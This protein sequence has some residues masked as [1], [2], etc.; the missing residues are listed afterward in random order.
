MAGAAV[1]GQAGGDQAGREDR[2]PYASL[3]F[4]GYCAVVM[5]ELRRPITGSELNRVR[6]GY[7]LRLAPSAVAGLLLR[8]TKARGRQGRLGRPANKC[9]VSC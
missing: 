8:G 2:G 5:H 6:N 4:G 9:P 3:T 1:T 7:S